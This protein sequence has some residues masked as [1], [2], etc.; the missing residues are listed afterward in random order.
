[1]VCARDKGPPVRPV[2]YLCPPPPTPVPFE[3]G[4]PCDEQTLAASSRQQHRTREAR[5]K[6]SERPDKYNDEGLGHMRQ[7]PNLILDSRVGYQLCVCMRHMQQCF[8]HYLSVN[9]TRALC[10]ISCF[11][12]CS[13]LNDSLK[14]PQHVLFWK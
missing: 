4:S 9:V 14:K 5:M 8:L 10:R 6:E 3:R 1:M 11:K 13:Y 12:Y 2:G 7:L